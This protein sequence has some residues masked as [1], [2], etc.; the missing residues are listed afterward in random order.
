MDRKGISMKKLVYVSDFNLSGSGY[1][2]ISVP[3]CTELTKLGYDIKAVGLGY[4]GEEHPFPFS[5][6]PCQGFGDARAMVNNLKFQW[7]VDLVI[8]ALD[9]PRLEMFSKLCKSLGLKMMAITPLENPPLTMSWAY[10]LQSIEKV[11][12]ISQLGEDEAKKAGIEAEH[13]VVGMD[14]KSWRMR[15]TEEYTKSR[16]ALNIS[17]DTLVVLTVADNQERKHLSKAF[18]IVSKVKH[19]KGVKVKYILVTKEHA[20]VGWKLRDLAMTYKIAPD[21][22]IMER[23]LSFGQLYALYAVADAFLLTSKAE[24]LNMAVLEA[25]SV[26]VPVVATACGSLPELLADGRGFLMETEYSHIDPWGNERRDFPYA[27][28]G[29]SSLDVIHKL[30]GKMELVS[31]TSARMYME[32]RTWDK[33]IQQLVSAMEKLDETK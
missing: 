29:A 19:E 3:I 16:E 20:E 31:V 14:T 17:P 30:K 2:N 10:I 18:E 6:I 21:L 15:T 26:G 13:L 25:M 24:G 28:S 22:M 32:S 12:F 1:L 4:T 5:I 9:I 23:G 8:V 7:G 27:E 11:F 33:P